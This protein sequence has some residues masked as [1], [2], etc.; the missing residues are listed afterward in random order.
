MS[1]QAVA[2]V[3]AHEVLSDVADRVATI[4][5]NRPDK[6]N[7]W[8]VTMQDELREALLAADSDDDVRAIVLTGAGRGF[9]AGADMTGLAA[10]AGR[11]EAPGP[12]NGGIAG[13]SSQRHSYMLA[14]KKPVIAAINGP[15]A[16]IG[17]VITLFCDIRYIADGARLT[18]AFARRGLIAEEGCA[19]LLPRLVG[20][21]NALDLLLSARMVDA[22][23]AEA[24]RFARVLPAEGF[25]AAVQAR[26]GEIAN[27]T[28]PRSLRI[29]KRQ[30]YEGLFQSLAEATTVADR[31]FALCQN[32]EDF[33]EGVAH[34]VE[35]RKPNFTGR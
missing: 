23:E 30:I 6:L 22:K 29:I 12:G 2:S 10:R 11:R 20:A 19:C 13:N 16:G 14:L 25:L 21:M 3:P 27:L 5:L 26:A 4:T 28:S 7:A 33:R 1:M 17:F 31:E 8:T 24:M 32:T 9:C 34:F 18:T 35:K 15:A